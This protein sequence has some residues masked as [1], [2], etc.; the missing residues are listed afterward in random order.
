[1][2]GTIPRT[3]EYKNI[4]NFIMWIKV[5]TDSATSEMWLLRKPYKTDH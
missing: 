1:M 3:I 5:K 2:N 4:C